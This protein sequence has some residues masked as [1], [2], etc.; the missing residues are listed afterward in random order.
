MKEEKKEALDFLALYEKHQGLDNGLKAQLRR[1]SE[2]DELRETPALYRLFPQSRPHDG[3]LRCAFLLPWV[4]DC[5]EGRRPSAQPFG[6]LLA[7]KKVSEMR[8]FQVARAPSPLDL[9]QLRRLAIQLKHPMLDWKRFGAMLYF[10]NPEQKRRLVEGYFIGQPS[11]T[12]Q[13]GAQS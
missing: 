6:K 11:T 8:V 7:E 2:P 3:W 9:I 12:E 13:Q 10:W 4:E 1:V 5:G